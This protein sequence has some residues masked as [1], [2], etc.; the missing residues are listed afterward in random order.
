MKWFLKLLENGADIPDVLIRFVNEGT[1]TFLYSAGVSLRV[2][3]P[4]F[5]TLTESV[6]SQFGES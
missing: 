2:G 5:K 6:Y 3:L 1:A 4:I